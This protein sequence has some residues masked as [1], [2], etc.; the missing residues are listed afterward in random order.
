MKNAQSEVSSKMLPSH[1]KEVHARHLVHLNVSEEIAIDTRTRLS[2]E[3][4]FTREYL[5]PPE[6]IRGGIS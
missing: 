6:I 3:S 1:I 2:S 4:N 5:S